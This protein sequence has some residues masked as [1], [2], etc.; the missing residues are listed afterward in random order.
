MIKKY[1]K[2]ASVIGLALT[3][4]LLFVA[5]AKKTIT[6]K[7]SD[8]MVIL[9]QRWAEKYMTSHPEVVVQVTGGGS[10]TGLSALNNGTTDFANASREMKKSE[11]DKLKQRFNT[12]G[13]EI[14]VAKDGVTI[15]TNASNTISE[16][17]IAQIRAIYL[18][19]ITNWKDVGG[20]DAQIVVYGR[21]NSSG[22]YVY[23]RDNVL[24]GK[25]YTSSM[26]SLPGTAAVV[27]AVVKDKNGIGYGGAAYAEGIKVIKV[28]KDESSVACAP[29]AETI[30]NNTY[31]ISRYLYMY[32]RSKPVGAMKEYVD[33][34]LSAEG[35]EIVTKV[36]YFP[37][38]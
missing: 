28:K 26:Q 32:S 17:T 30:K 1:I 18:G 15:Y 8:T 22:T 27:N 20:N 37:A 24:N 38:N 9:A 11:I 7:G 6:I 35:Q 3:G 16:L 4:S 33:W 21:E 10:G 19:E 5:A 36:G 2:T 25:D 29:T 13:Y 31:P 23:F 34:I 12:L 14:K